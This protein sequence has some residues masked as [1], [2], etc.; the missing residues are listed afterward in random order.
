M[1]HSRH[2]IPPTL[3]ITVPFEKPIFVSV[4]Y[5][6][7]ETGGHFN[8]IKSCEVCFQP[9]IKTRAKCPGEV[10]YKKHGAKKSEVN[11]QVLFCRYGR[12][13]CDGGQDSEGA[14]EWRVWRGDSAGNGQ[15]PLRVS[16]QGSAP[17]HIILSRR[18]LM[19]IVHLVYTTQSFQY[20][21]NSLLI[22]DIHTVSAGV[23]LLSNE[24]N[25][26][27][28]RPLICNTFFGDF[29]IYTWTQMKFQLQKN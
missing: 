3:F 24:T 17:H 10:L 19:L 2:C 28:W 27:W 5:S 13:H 16:L 25:Q 29:I 18:S 15:I 14:A 21:L 26:D 22:L 1:T 9:G 20:L 11:P 23:V 12:S 8:S 4:S 6:V 7:C